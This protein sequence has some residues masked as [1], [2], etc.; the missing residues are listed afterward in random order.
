VVVWPASAGVQIGETF[1]PNDICG[2]MG[3]HY[4]DIQTG[5]PN[6]SYASPIDGVIT[7]WS[8]QGG[9]SAPTI[10]FKV[11]RQTGPAIFKIVG[12]SG[13]AGPDPAAVTQFPIRVPVQAG[14]V[15]GLYYPGI[16]A[17]RRSPAPGYT[18]HRFFGNATPGGETNYAPITS[19]TIQLDVAA[20]VEPDCD[21]DGFGD[22]TQDPDVSSCTPP[23]S[24]GDTAPPDTTITKKPKDKTSKKTTTFEFSS[25]EPGST[26]ECSLDGAQFAPCSSPDTVKVKKGKHSFQVR[27]KDAAGNLDGS[28]ATDDWKVKKKRK[29]K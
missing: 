23:G 24:T 14:D 28:P 18:V 19:P 9:P 17:C 27:A 29:K 21:G 26:F 12:E 7:S 3:M 1:L 25:N 6:S 16:G 10:D 5:S 8:F 20:I 15:L 11:A 22:E 13:S 2:G 4:T